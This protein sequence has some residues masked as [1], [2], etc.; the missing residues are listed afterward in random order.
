MNDQNGFNNQFNNQPMNN[1]DSMPGGH[2]KKKFFSNSFMS[3]NSSTMVSA[4]DTVNSNSNNTVNWSGFTD[5][6]TVAVEQQNN[7]GIVQEQ[8]EVQV[9][10]P[11][12]FFQQPL[13]QIGQQPMQE[14][15]IG[16]LQPDLTQASVEVLDDT[17][18]TL[19]G[20]EPETLD[21]YNT[22]Q[23]VESLE[24]YEMQDTPQNNSSIQ[25][26]T[27]DQ[28]INN[29][30]QN[31]QM[32]AYNQQTYYNNSQMM[33]GVQ[34]QGMA[35]GV[36]VGVP[37]MENSAIYQSAQQS[38]AQPVQQTQIETL[39]N[40]VVEPWMSNQP[41][42]TET[43]EMP[44]VLEE[45]VIPANQRED[46]IRKQQEEAQR[47]AM[48]V[49]EEVVKPAQNVDIKADLLEKEYVGEDYPKIVMSPFNLG[50]FL[51]G[52]AYFA[53]RKMF[54][55]TVLV[56]LGALA[57]LFYVQIPYNYLCLL[58]LHIFV[59]LIV[60]RIY[61]L[62]VKMIA[63]STAKRNNKRKEP[64]S[65][66]RLATVLKNK[67]RVMPINAIL[68]ICLF[69][70][71]IITISF[72]VLPK[73]NF[74]KL[75]TKSIGGRPSKVK[76]AKYDGTIYFDEESNVFDYI[77][78]E[79]PAGFEKISKKI[80][81]YKYVTDGT[82]MFNECSFRIGVI[83]DF[84]SGNSYVVKMAAYDEKGEEI[85]TSNTKG[86]E[87]TNY[88]TEDATSTIYYKGT[89]VDDNAI[90]FEYKMGNDSNKATCNSYFL[91]VM[92][93]IELKKED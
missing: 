15:V 10:Q 71:S 38:Y 23:N 18:A 84:T 35:Q 3:D 67:G 83:K 37:T 5:N 12:Q 1:G 32:G 78:F 28:G 76:E 31:N 51:F 27:I 30:Y 25:V 57:I 11:R 70:A 61:V 47:M 39:D 52:A 46:M 92:D 36:G 45:P 64:M 49:L 74:S 93:S 72:Y 17:N 89:T 53:Y 85:S 62:K 8:A 87:W 19:S 59:G 65:Q 21:D 86:I 41:L 4:S 80:H 42:S 34:N 73:N 29:M 6:N 90:L 2:T 48:P 50:G 14:Q 16:T 40:G 81:S 60:N 24:N 56:L 22:N 7:T 13:N 63:K 75:I 66:E 55:F 88:Y 33:P 20:S 54:L 69:A 58:A 44:D 26:P 43:L 91:E 77:N 9:Q 68:V 79:V 82:G